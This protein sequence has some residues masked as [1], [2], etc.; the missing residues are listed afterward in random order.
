MVLD[1]FFYLF[2]FSISLSTFFLLKKKQI[3]CCN[4]KI[5]FSTFILFLLPICF[6]A[7]LRYGIG[8]DYF[9]YER[10]HQ[11]LGQT[12]VIDYF[13]EHFIKENLDYYVEPGYYLLNRLFCFNYHFTLFFCELLIFF[14]LYKGVKNLKSIQGITLA[15]FIYLSTQFIYSLNGIRFAIAISVVFASFDSIIKRN[16]KLFL[17]YMILAYCFHKTCFICVSFYFLGT[18]K[19]KRLNNIRNFF[20]GCFVVLFVFFMGDIMELLKSFP[21][22][23]RYFISYVF[24]GQRRFSPVILM[25]IIPVMIPILIFGKN[26]FKLDSFCVLF[27]IYL[28]EF[29]FR[30][31]GL[32]NTW[33]TRMVR[34]VQMSEIL[35]IPLFLLN[36][37]NKLTR[38]FLIFY[39]IVW[40]IFDFCYYAI[41]NDAGDSLPYQ[42]VFNH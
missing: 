31:T 33:F 34:P 5:T 39:Y 21:L 15:I 9:S 42:L 29:P 18:F 41:V 17:I 4:M 2:I 10:L 35:L 40:Y 1:C 6:M 13:N 24:R 30:I 23:H 28:L 19:S 37:K 8:S 14:F 27:R 12:T 7:G 32:I 38:N 25:H 22:F 16:F 26:A 20:L 36:I 3:G 11:L